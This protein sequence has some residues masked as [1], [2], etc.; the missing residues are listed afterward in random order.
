ML[1]LSTSL[2][3]AKLDGDLANNFDY[4]VRKPHRTGYISWCIPYLAVFIIKINSLTFFQ[5][6]RYTT[7]STCSG[8]H[9]VDRMIYFAVHSA[10]TTTGHWATVYGS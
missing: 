1:P 8:S 5:P 6:N 2:A 9:F 10:Y 3:K 4:D 7:K